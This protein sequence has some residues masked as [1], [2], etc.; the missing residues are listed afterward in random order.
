MMA[1]QWAWLLASPAGFSVPS[2]VLPPLGQFCFLPPPRVG[3]SVSG[4][5]RQVG[6]ANVGVVERVRYP[7]ATIYP[8]DN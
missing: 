7:P 3:G 5:F 2:P 8:H 4:N 6:I 1:W